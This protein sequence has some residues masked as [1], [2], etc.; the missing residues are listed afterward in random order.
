MQENQTFQL[1][2]SFSIMREDEVAGRFNSDMVVVVDR[3]SF[4]DRVRV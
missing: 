4:V 2:I 3:G 1:D